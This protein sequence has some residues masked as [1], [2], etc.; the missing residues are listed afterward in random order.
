MNHELVM[1]RGLN[2]CKKEIKRLNAECMSTA[3]KSYDAENWKDGTLGQMQ[4]MVQI[5]LER[6]KFENYLTLVKQALSDMPK[7]YRT[8]LVTVYIKNVSKEE[9]CQRYCVS[10][11]TVYRK[12]AKSRECFKNKLL[13]LG[14]DEKWFCQ[15]YGQTDWVGGMLSRP[16]NGARI[17]E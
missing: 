11:S 5:A 3:L 14:C 7:G 4:R 13:L 16:H 9:I 17:S 12:L 2:Y 8:L 15:M 1:L 10:K 6:E